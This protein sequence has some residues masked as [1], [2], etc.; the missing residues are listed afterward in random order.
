MLVGATNVVKI[1]AFA[2]SLEPLTFR[3]SLALPCDSHDGMVLPFGCVDETHQGAKSTC[4]I[5]AR[6]VGFTDDMVRLHVC[7]PHRKQ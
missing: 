4:R 6:T 5:R 2:V 3:F 1:I 7:A